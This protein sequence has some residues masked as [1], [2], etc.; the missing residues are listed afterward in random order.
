MDQIQTLA[1]HMQADQE[2]VSSEP[3]SS[4]A[5]SDDVVDADFEVVD[6][7]ETSKKS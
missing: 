5:E 7:E 3:Q 6:E 1:P 4:K 2:N